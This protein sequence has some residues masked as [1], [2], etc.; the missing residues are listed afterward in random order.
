MLNEDFISAAAPLARADLFSTELPRFNAAI[1]NPPYRKIRS[2]SAAR[3]WLRS[4]GIETSNLYTGFV[5]LIIKLL[6]TD[7]Q[8]VAITPRSFCN[9]PYFKPF[10]A[11]F[12][13]RILGFQKPIE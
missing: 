11:D 10:R 3:L 8:L 2:S 7:G 9:G 13:D 5:A 6:A 4:A 12:L 1:V